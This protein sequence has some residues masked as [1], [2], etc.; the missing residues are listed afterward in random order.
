MDSVDDPLR[1][2]HP[3]T[4]V[5]D[6]YPADGKNILASEAPHPGEIIS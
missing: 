6:R 3:T 4:G 1:R 2:R 5:L